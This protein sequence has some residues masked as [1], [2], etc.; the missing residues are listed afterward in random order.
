MSETVPTIA[1]TANPEVE[2]LNKKIK[3][4]ET[5]LGKKSSELGEVQKFANQADS[6]LKAVASDQELTE[7]V[8]GAY[9]KTYGGGAPVP[10]EQPDEKGKKTDVNGV[11][12]AKLKAVDEDVKSVKRTQREQI[13]GQF[14]EKAG[15]AS[16]PVE[17]Q[18]EVRRAIEEHLNVFGQSVESAPVEMLSR[19]LDKAYKAVDVEKAIADGKLEGYAGAYTNNSGAMPH[20]KGR[21][22]DAPEEGTLDEKQAGWAKKL[23]LDPKKV[24]EVYKDRDNERTRIPEA[25]KKKQ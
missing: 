19:V 6:I 20:M 14:E 15:I 10:T 1:P 22:L 12:D 11:Q 5:E 7:K 4:L 24:E 9:Y 21:I 3:E 13:I 18:K 2:N 16:L 17:K 8:R 25:E 23:N